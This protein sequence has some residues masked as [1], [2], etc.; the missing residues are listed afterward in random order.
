[1]NIN[2]HFQSKIFGITKLGRIPIE[3]D[4]VYAIIREVIDSRNSEKKLLDKAEQVTNSGAWEWDIVN[5][6]FKSSLNWR[7]I[8]GIET[9]SI[10]LNELFALA[11]PEDIDVINKISQKAFNREIPVYDLEHRIIRKSD[12]DKNP[13]MFELWVKLF[14]IRIKSPSRTNHSRHHRAQAGR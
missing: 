5:D 10:T 12:G 7:K 2:W 1:M 3:N 8:H 4:E 14:S 11:H 13:G 9:E 6:Q